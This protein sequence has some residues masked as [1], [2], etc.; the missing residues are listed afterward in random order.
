MRNALPQIARD[1]GN[2]MS[3]AYLDSVQA[4]YSSMAEKPSYER[5]YMT[6]LGSSSAGAN[7]IQY[8][9]GEKSTGSLRNKNGETVTF[10]IHVSMNVDS[11]YLGDPYKDPVDYVFDRTWCQGIHGNLANPQMN[12]PPQMFFEKWFESF[13]GSGKQDGGEVAMY[14]NR[15]MRKYAGV[16]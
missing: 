1:I 10:S 5:T 3:I 14:A 16:G 6:Y 2:R 8:S 11:S 9:F 13:K 15:G 7:G 12:E 4:F